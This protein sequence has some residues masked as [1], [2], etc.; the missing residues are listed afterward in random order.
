VITVGRFYGGLMALAAAWSL[1]A[2]V[3]TS[4]VVLPVFLL[5]A[6]YATAWGALVRAFA[7][8]RRGAWQSLVGLVA[9]D[10][11]WPVAG[12][13]TGRP[14]S[15]LTLLSVTVHTALLALLLHPDS[16]E[17]VGA[18]EPRRGGTARWGAARTPDAP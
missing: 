14:V 4:L 2:V 9:V 12:W 6:G 17:W 11:L 16:R 10:L 15:V 7:A 8:H 3:F 13:L 1:L 18:D 5:L